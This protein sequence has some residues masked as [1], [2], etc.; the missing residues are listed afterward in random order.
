MACA[1]EWPQGYSLFNLSR[2]EKVWPKSRELF[3]TEAARQEYRLWT[4]GCPVSA[5][6]AW[7]LRGGLWVKAASS[8]GGPIVDEVFLVLLAHRR[9]FFNV[10]GCWANS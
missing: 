8:G 4:M 10:L 3:P 5:G 1:H 2:I 9:G 7:M 6:L